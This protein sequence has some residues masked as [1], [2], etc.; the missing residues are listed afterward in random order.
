MVMRFRAIVAVLIVC[1]GTVVLAAPPAQL[2]SAAFKNTI[3]DGGSSERWFVFLFSPHCG[4]CKAMEPAWE[5]LAEMME[6]SN[7]NEEGAV[8]R[9]ATVD[10]TE[11]KSIATMLDVHGY[12]TL[13]AFDRSVVHEYDGDRSAESLHAFATAVDLTTAGG[14][15]KGYLRADGSV[16]PSYADLLVRVPADAAEIVSFALGTSRPAALLVAAMLVVA[17]ALLAIL[18]TPPPAAQF[19]VVECPAGVQPG[20]TFPVEVITKAHGLLRRRPRKRVMNVSA[21]AGIQPG[22]SFFVPL[23]APP[24][25]K[26]RGATTKQEATKKKDS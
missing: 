12:P 3:V 8:V 9:L 19:L 22:A 26:A 5:A 10:A 23:V 11:E 18:A 15:R 17:G 14:R 16:R 1:C 6:V 24:K 4:H 7:T 25:A 20:Q 21:P 2:D 13:L